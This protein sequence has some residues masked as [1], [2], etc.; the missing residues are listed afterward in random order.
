MK[1][2]AFVGADRDNWVAAARDAAWAEVI[3]PSPD[4]GEALKKLFTK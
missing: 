2:I 1:T 4:H 3:E